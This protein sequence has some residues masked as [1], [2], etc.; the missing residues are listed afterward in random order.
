LPFIRKNGWDVVAQLALQ[1]KAKS[2]EGG[3]DKVANFLMRASRAES[4]TKKSN[5][6]NRAAILGFLRRCMS[7]LPTSPPTTKRVA[8]ELTWGPIE[9]L[10]TEQSLGGKESYLVDEFFASFEITREVGDLFLR[11]VVNELVEGLAT[12][13]NAELKYAVSAAWI[14]R[15]QLPSEMRSEL[16]SILFRAMYQH[17]SDWPWAAAAF[18]YRAE[19]GA[20]AILEHLPVESMVQDIRI[21]GSSSGYSSPL[22]F[23]PA[24]VLRPGCDNPQHVEIATLIRLVELMAAHVRSNSPLSFRGPGKPERYGRIV[25][26]WATRP[27]QAQPEHPH[28]DLTPAQEIDALLC[29]LVA[30]DASMTVLGSSEKAMILEMLDSE[31]FREPVPSILRARLKPRTWESTT[32]P[33]L[34]GKDLI[35]QWIN[36]RMKFWRT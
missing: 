30:L 3:P 10:A 7:F 19:I 34:P 36:R 24:M 9:V 29:L 15:T 5:A 27:D 33:D 8:K 18:L 28:P 12:R 31:S 26:R 16:N 11:S 17:L 4:N 22:G 14:T 23:A 25:P 35:E 1:L 32:I 6:K 21:Y 2:M 20:E 13:K